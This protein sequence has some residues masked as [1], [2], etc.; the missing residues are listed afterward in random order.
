MKDGDLF[1]D[2]DGRIGVVLYLIEAYIT[3]GQHTAPCRT[4]PTAGMG[5]LFDTGEKLILYKEE[6]EIIGEE[7]NGAYILE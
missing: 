3:I 5:L 6:I 2:A 1:I 4:K 7:Y